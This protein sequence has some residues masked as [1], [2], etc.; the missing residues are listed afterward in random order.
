[1]VTGLAATT[2]LKALT[3][4][5][6]LGASLPHQSPVTP[7]TRVIFP[8]LSRFQFRGDSKYL[9]DLVALIDCPRLRPMNVSYSKHLVDVHVSQLFLLITLVEDFKLTRFRRAPVQFYDYMVYICIEA[10]QADPHPSLLTLQFP[11]QWSNLPVRTT[12]QHLIQYS[13]ILSTVRHLTVAK[14]C[15]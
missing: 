8:S 10:M 12:R 3:I 5:F 1:L 2:R 14:L 15:G 6:R 4:E 9:D 11:Y 13:F 7:P